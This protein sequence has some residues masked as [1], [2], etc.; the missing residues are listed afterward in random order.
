VTAGRTRTVR[1]ARWIALAVVCAALAG[2]ARPD[3]SRARRAAV[4]ETF[5]EYLALRARPASE[6]PDPIG[7]LLTPKL[8]FGRASSLL[9]D[10]VTDDAVRIDECVGP[11]PRA[12]DA[13]LAAPGAQ[14]P[15]STAPSAFD[16]S[17]PL[18]LLA[19]DEAG[20]VPGLDEAL[21]DALAL[22]VLSGAARGQSPLG[23]IGLF[24]RA[25]YLR[26]AAVVSVWDVAND[27]GETELLRRLHS[28]C[29]PGGPID[30]LLAGL[31]DP[32]RAV[33]AQEAWFADRDDAARGVVAVLGGVGFELERRARLH[34]ARLVV[35]LLG[36]DAGGGAR[37]AAPR[38]AEMAEQIE[39][40]LRQRGVR[41][42][43]LAGEDGPRDTQ[44][45]LTARG[46]EQVVAGVRAVID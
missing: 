11:V 37:A 18:V 40:A 1:G 39:R 33:A 10:S 13:A 35:V 36:L 41:V 42:V 16:R 14:Q 15:D 27:L 22:P 17:A 46:I 7:P 2:W 25:R 9:F 26:V 43:A 4:A 29:E 3:G 19:C 44:G 38:T 20:L 21:A 32:A 34:G 23:H 31:R 30:E 6:E 5:G 28:Y 24:E 12:L 8:V 45:R